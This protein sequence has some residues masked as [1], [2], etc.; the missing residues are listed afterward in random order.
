MLAAEE[1]LEATL[2]FFR[3]LVLAISCQCFA[4]PGE[5]VVDG[6]VLAGIRIE[7]AANCAHDKALII[8]LLLTQPRSSGYHPQHSGR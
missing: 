5:V 2:Q 1:A 4:P 8:I 3:M 7:R 6:A